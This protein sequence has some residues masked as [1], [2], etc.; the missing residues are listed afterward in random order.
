MIG[1]ILR[2][3]ATPLGSASVR[4]SIERINFRNRCRAGEAAGAGVVVGGF[5]GGRVI[6]MKCAS[7]INRPAGFRIIRWPFWM[8]TSGP[9]GDRVSATFAPFLANCL[10]GAAFVAL[11]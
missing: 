9:A 10:A 11:A 8:T 4:V 3:L 7:G 2:R 1:S 5:V 6:A